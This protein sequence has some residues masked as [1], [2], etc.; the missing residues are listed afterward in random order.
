MRHSGR[1]KCGDRP[2]V[3]V[4]AS[5]RSV[6]DRRVPRDAVLGVVPTVPRH[7]EVLPADG[8]V[9]GGQDTATPAGRALALRSEAVSL[10]VRGDGEERRGGQG[11]EEERRDVQLPGAAQHEDAGACA[12]TCENGRKEGEE[13]GT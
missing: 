4:P 5:A 2:P 9:R 13:G 11:E 8:T 7:R 3:G 6:A 1:S 10:R 12:G